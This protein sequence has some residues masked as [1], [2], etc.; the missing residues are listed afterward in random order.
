MGGREGKAMQEGETGR[1]K[2]G[3]SGGGGGRERRWKK[4]E[5]IE[6]YE[7]ILEWGLDKKLDG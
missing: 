1:E 2:S 7:G 6:T 5:V 3:G 4:G